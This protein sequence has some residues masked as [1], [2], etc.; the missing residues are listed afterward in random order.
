MTLDVIS[1]N[2]RAAK[3]AKVAQLPKKKYTGGMIIRM[4]IIFNH[5]W[6]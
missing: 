1:H 4:V 5:C 6:K 2:V 3:A